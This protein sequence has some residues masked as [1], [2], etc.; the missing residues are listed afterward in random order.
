MLLQQGSV[1]LFVQCLELQQVFRCDA[2]APRRSSLEGEIRYA[3]S[4]CD[5]FYRVFHNAI[6]IF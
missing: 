6:S 4:E 5:E 3:P 1:M 2:L